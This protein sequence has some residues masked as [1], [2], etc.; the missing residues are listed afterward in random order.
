MSKK[1]GKRQL[2]RLLSLASPTMLLIVGDD[3]VSQSLVRRGLV[4]PKWPDK[5]TAWLHITP[6]GMRVLADA[7]AAG[8]L[9]QFM[10]IPK[11]VRQ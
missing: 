5:P 10:K 4:A 9:E 1:L 7:L 6:Q 3:R 8:D 2:E 11:G